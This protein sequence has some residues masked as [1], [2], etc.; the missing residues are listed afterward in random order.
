M[1]FAFSTRGRRT[2]S[3]AFAVALSGLHVAF[4]LA[5]ALASAPTTARADDVISDPELGPPP[6]SAESPAGDDVISDPEL[7]PKPHPG[8]A[9]PPPE[10]DHAPTTEP[11]TWRIV[12]E[13]R[14]GVATAWQPPWTVPVTNAPAGT[15]TKV[16]SNQDVVEGTTVGVLEAQQRV[17]NAV[18]VS[19]GLRARHDFAT[20]RD[21]N[22]REELDVEP[23][24]GFVDARIADGLHVRAGYQIVT[25]G[26]F[27]LFSA[28]NFLAVND[29]RN[30]PFT[31]PDASAIAQ[32]A[33]RVDYD[34]TSAL[35]LQAYYLPFFEPDVVALYGTNYALLSPFDRVSPGPQP[36]ATIPSP[37]VSRS[38][39]A[40]T[41]TSAL[42]TLGPSPDFS[43]PQGSLRAL[44]HGAAGELAATFGTALERLP[45]VNSSL[46]ANPPTLSANSPIL[47][48]G[49]FYVASVDGATD[50]GPAQVGF[51]AAFMKNR[52][53]ATESTTT[54]N[55]TTTTFG[56]QKAD[57]V[58]FGLRAE[59][60][61][62]DE[63]GVGAEAFIAAALKSPNLA[64][65]AYLFFDHLGSTYF[66]QG[67]AV[68]GYYAPEKTPF[69]FELGGLLATGPSVLVFPRIQWEAL[70]RFYLELG[71]GF[72]TG[73]GT[74][75]SPNPTFGGAYRDIGQVF[76]GIRYIP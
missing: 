13:T 12:L 70:T 29:L 18:L 8:T 75:L 44:L 61:D 23:V 28:T 33:L 47:D 21:G 42:G 69:R 19:V 74:I 64:N 46:S 49:R 71:A 54:T 35:S 45:A 36:N 66:S 76:T 57:L 65:S 58:Q 63:V 37:V 16:P 48:Y 20:R 62:G 30:G 7:S 43:R 53:V 25:L 60:A 34:P 14:W 50:V 67:V 24:S 22:P 73:R 59:Y 5:F 52:T 11:T 26:R 41:S 3:R 72:V 31:M 2:G 27:D 39:I 4:A 1:T 9:T 10:N 32:P 56:Q 40:S 6:K 55:G 38:A 17:S 68:G 51:E 15:T